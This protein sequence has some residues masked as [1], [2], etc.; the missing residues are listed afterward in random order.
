MNRNE[1]DGQYAERMVPE[2]AHA[3]T[4]WEHVERYRF[5][6]RY[7]RGKR[8]LDIACGEG[9]GAV[10]L[11]LAGAASVIGVDISAAACDHARRKYQLDARV[12]DAHAIPLADGSVDVVTSF[13]T[14]EH[15]A[16]PSRF[17]RECAR[18]LAPG[19][20]FIV[21]TPNRPVYNA[22]G[23]GNPFHVRELDEREFVDLL[24][25]RF[26]SVRLFT[27]FPRTASVWSLRSLPAERSPWL[28][29]RGFWRLSSWLCPAI[30]AELAR[31]MRAAADQAVLVRARFPGALFNPYLV[32]PYSARSGEQAYYLIAVAEGGRRAE[33]E[34]GASERA[35]PVV[36]ERWSAS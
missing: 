3:R 22:E 19:G 18:V 36:R 9:F 24:R 32:R 28:R 5:A 27:Q 14:I 10:G 8:V 35:A 16:D 34:T 23:A 2:E 6:A 25:A 17:V 4:F 20:T 31:G 26:E 12:G 29:I 1:V 11:G 7:V 33:P 13:E 21:S 15:V 30:R